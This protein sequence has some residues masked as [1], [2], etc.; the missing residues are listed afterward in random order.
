MFVP[1][2]QEDLF[3]TFT[4]FRMFLFALTADIEQMYR[5]IQL[6]SE[7]RSFHKVLWRE[8][9]NDPI[10]IY[11]LN[12]VTF[13]NRVGSLSRYSH[14]SSISRRWTWKIPSYLSYI[15]TWFLHWRTFKRGKYVW[16]C[17]LSSQWLLSKGDFNLRKRG[18]NDPRLTSDLK[19]NSP[20]THTSLDPTETIK[21]LGL[22][23]NPSTGSIVYTVN[24]SETDNQLRHLEQKESKYC[25]HIKEKHKN[26]RSK[27]ET[28]RF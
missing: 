7:H 1:T 20:N 11:T 28:H 24:F 15:K 10:K 12:T 5:Q 18:S 14:A 22:F 3:S 8:T 13:W 21:T 25:C 27:R 9:F 26:G 23:W 19:N 16:K 2:I 6:C 4:R 17:S